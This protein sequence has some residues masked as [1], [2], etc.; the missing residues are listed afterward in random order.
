MAYLCYDICLGVLACGGGQK[1]LNTALLPEER[2]PYGEKPSVP[3][4]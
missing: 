3:G 1:L 2:M 4:A